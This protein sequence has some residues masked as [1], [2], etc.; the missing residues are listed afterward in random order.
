MNAEGTV[1]IGGNR[2]LDVLDGEARKAVLAK[3][4]RMDLGLRAYLAHAGEPIEYVYFPIDGVMSMIAKL[5]TGT[6]VEVATVGNEGLVGIPLFLGAKT[7]PGPVFCQVPGAALRLSASD[8]LDLAASH[9][10]FN[11]LL[12]RYTH[13][14]FVQ[15]SQNTAC[16]RAHP[17]DERCARWLLMTQDRVHT[18]EFQLTQEFIAQMLGVRRTTVNTVCGMLERAGF[19][20]YSRGSVRVKDRAGLERST[21]MCYAIIREEYESLLKR[22]E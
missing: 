4:R 18:D 7:V 3:A 20:D 17:V 19:I 10:A 11:A 1:A 5:E 8:F 22:P 13:A 6:Q 14:L 12:R 2:L 16:N 9:P 15:I 21:C